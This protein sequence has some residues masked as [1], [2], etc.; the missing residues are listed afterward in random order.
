MVVIKDRRHL[1]SKWH[2]IRV[3]GSPC[4]LTSPA[5]GT[6]PAYRRDFCRSARL[7]TT[8]HSAGLTAAKRKK[9]RDGVSL[10]FCVGGPCGDRTHDP[11]IQSANIRPDTPSTRYVEKPGESAPKQPSATVK[12]P[13][14]SCQL[15]DA[16]LQNVPTDSGRLTSCKGRVMTTPHVPRQPPNP[17][18]VLNLGYEATPPDGLVTLIYPL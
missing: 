12:N 4:T 18:G 8:G 5:K 16:C 9:T 7:R 6:L 3:R 10:V 13:A 14:K 2:R 17:A 1:P 11:R 15:W